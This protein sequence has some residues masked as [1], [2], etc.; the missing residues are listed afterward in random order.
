MEQKILITRPIFPD[1]ADR[2]RE[3]FD[4]TMNEGPRYT[5]DQ[6]R[7]ALAGKDGVLIAGGEKIDGSVLEGLTQLK[8]LCVTAAGY[9]N[10]DVEA[11][12]RAG[13]TGTNSPGPA[14]ETVADFAWG[15]MIAT[16]RRLVE[17]AHW[18]EQGE[19]KSSAGSRFFGT[20]ICDKTLGIIGM[21][22]IGQAIARRAVGF[23]TKVIYYNRHRLDIAI[24]KD[25]RAVYATKEDLLRQADFVM[26]ALPYTPGNRHIIGEKEL[27]SMQPTAML[28][29]IAR[30]GLIDEAAL[31]EALRSQQIAAAGLDVFEGEPAIHPGLMGLPNV[32]LCPHIAG[33]TAAAQ[34]GLVAMAADNLIAILTKGPAAAVPGSVINPGVSGRPV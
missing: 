26:L 3:Y 12:T 29:N 31:A 24:E 32:V 17:A 7:E 22:R 23:R 2:L 1:L 16:G 25:C 5:P 15:L 28:F 34:H 9:N 8:A 19:W 20:N 11:L 27:K 4:V 6:L 18:V 33:A 13:V 21:G 30:G 14:D 10:I